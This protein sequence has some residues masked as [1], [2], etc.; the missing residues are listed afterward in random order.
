M[1]PAPPLLALP[2]DGPEE[3]WHG[4]AKSTV[5]TS[6]TA[7]G[8]RLPLEAD[9]GCWKAGSQVRRLGQAAHLCLHLENGDSNGTYLLAMRGRLK[10]GYP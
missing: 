5:Q 2:V 8:E 1:S 4:E 7:G 6:S 9:H 10:G 3:T